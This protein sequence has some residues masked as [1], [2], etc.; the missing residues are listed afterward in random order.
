MEGQLLTM[1]QVTAILGIIAPP[2]LALVKRTKRLSDQAK[3]MIIL[4][5]L[6]LV[7]GLAAFLC[8]DI[9]PL[10]CSVVD[11]E[12]C[13]GIIIGYVSLVVGQAFA[14]YKMLYRPSGIDAKIAGK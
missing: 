5:A 1:V 14:W 10:A 2:I 6:V 4:V 12:G 3:D 9:D 8:G 7:G 13:I 11:L